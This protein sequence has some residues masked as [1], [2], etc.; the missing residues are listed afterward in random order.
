MK[1]HI[2]TAKGAPYQ[3]RVMSTVPTVSAD[4]NCANCAHAQCVKLFSNKKIKKKSFFQK[5]VW[6]KKKSFFQGK[7]WS[8]RNRFF[9][10]RVIKNDEFLSKKKKRARLPAFP[11]MFGPQ[12]S[13]S[14]FH[15]TVLRFAGTF[16]IITTHSGTA[17]DEARIASFHLPVFGILRCSADANRMQASLFCWLCCQ[18]RRELSSLE[19]VLPCGLGPKVGPNNR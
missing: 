1:V 12:R 9:Q 8:K 3:G 18:R 13:L 14:T 6:L 5:E 15:G 7:S 4:P 16:Q 19:V 2:A 10:W 17:E 11:L